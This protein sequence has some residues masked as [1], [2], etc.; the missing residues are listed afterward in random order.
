[1]VRLEL[2]L[3]TLYAYPVGGNV[4]TR[5]AD[6]IV[7]RHWNAGWAGGSTQPLSSIYVHIPFCLHFCQFCGFAKE[8]YDKASA[9]GYLMALAKEIEMVSSAIAADTRIEAVYFGGGTASTLTINQVKYLKTLLTDCF[10]IQEG[11]EFTFEG[12]CLTL[13][14]PQYLEGLAALG[15]SRLSFGVQLSHAGAR[16]ALNLRPRMAALSRLVASAND[17]FKDVAADY[18]YGWPGFSPKAQAADLITALQEVPATTYEIFRFEP[19]DASPNLIREFS[20]NGLYVPGYELYSEV[21]NACSD[22]LDDLGYRRQSYSVFSSASTAASDLKY[23]R[24][25]YGWGMGNIIGVGVGAQ[26]FYRGL[27]WG[28]TPDIGSYIDFIEQNALPYEVTATYSPVEKELVTWPRRGWILKSDVARASSG[29]QSKF[30]RLVSEGLIEERQYRYEICS[31]LWAAV[32]YLMNELLPT[33]DQEKISTISR[34]KAG[35]RGINLSA[36]EA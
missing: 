24:H 21:Y 8:L 12:E 6:G 35:Q 15:Y 9:E 10:D 16:R 7:R 1:M 36:S 33:P 2:P 5:G 18:I 28:A 13:S 32:P 34:Y 17:L 11:A 27:M 20:R 26:S 14:R 30:G 19:L 22:A 4:G 3:E 31:S 23:Y 29:Y 25:Y